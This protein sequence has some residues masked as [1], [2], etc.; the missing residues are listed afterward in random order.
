MLVFFFLMQP[1]PFFSELSEHFMWKVKGPSEVKETNSK[2]MIQI[3][4]SP[5]LTD[6]GGRCY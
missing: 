6:D 3:H 5:V 1:F 2:D 4:S